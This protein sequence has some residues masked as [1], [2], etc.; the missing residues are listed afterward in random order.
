M[1]PDFGLTAG[2]Y[3]RH[4][5]GFPASFFAG[6]EDFGVGRRGQTLVDLGTGTGTLARGFARRGCRVIALDPSAPMLEQ[7]RALDAAEGLTV[8]YRLG[9][10]EETGLDAASAEVVTAGQCWHWFDRPRAAAEARRILEPGGALMMAHFDWL[11]IPGNV[12]H[13]TETLILS[14][15]PDWRGARMAAPYNAWYFDLRAAGFTGIES[16]TF[17]RD[18]VYTHEAWR[19]RIRASAGVGASLS[20]E[21][22]AEFDAKHA[23][24]LSR[25]FA[26]DPMN[27]PHRCWAVWGRKP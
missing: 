10:A 25:A 1:T 5:A 17:E 14:Y 12:V 7:A 2:D 21:K 4:R 20:P 8:D 27:V 24:L 6:I 9:R 15:S 13:E 3:A 19:G 22:V 18:V 16:F 23:A 11:S 26:V